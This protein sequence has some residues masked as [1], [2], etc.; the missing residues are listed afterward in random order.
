M[1]DINK[2]EGKTLEAYGRGIVDGYQDGYL[3]ALKNVWSALKENYSIDCDLDDVF[4]S[5]FDIR[6]ALDVASIRPGTN[7]ALRWKEFLE[8][9]TEEK[10]DIYWD[11]DPSY[12]TTGG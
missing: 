9:E 2:L 1:I 8:D 3:A 6:G 11:A 12:I 5:D 4:W 10:T 7:V